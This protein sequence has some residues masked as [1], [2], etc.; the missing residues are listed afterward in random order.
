MLKYNI[1][2][3]DWGINHHVH[4]SPALD[5]I[6]GHFKLVYI[7]RAYFSKIN[8]NIIP[9]PVLFPPIRTEQ[10]KVAVML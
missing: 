5:L 4:K 1:H 7:L 2:L 6:P 9:S 8:C 3:A 10:I